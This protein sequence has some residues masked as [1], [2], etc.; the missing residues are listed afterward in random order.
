MMYTMKKK[1]ENSEKSV[2][3]T[4]KIMV[5]GHHTFKTLYDKLY[6]RTKITL[7]LLCL[8]QCWS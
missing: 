1:T 2:R 3:Y 6:N 7:D 4:Q 5:T 8:A